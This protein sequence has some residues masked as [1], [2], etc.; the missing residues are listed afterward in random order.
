MTLTEKLISGVIDSP[1]LLS[2][3]NFN[4]PIYQS[5]NLIFI[6]PSQCTSHYEVF[7]PL[8]VLSKD[9]NLLYN[10]MPLPDVVSSIRSILFN[11]RAL[12]TSY[13]N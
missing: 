6:K 3:I 10:L 12:S 13:L 1:I 5:M 11:R 9:L 2:E 7:K 4:V 8:S